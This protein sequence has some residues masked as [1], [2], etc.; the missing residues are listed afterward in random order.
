M[1]PGAPGYYLQLRMMVQ[2]RA[3]EPRV[4]VGNEI[5]VVIKDN[6]EEDF[7]EGTKPGERHVPCKTIA[8]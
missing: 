5:I 1:L 6:K 8:E 3:K 7:L 4:I 2:N